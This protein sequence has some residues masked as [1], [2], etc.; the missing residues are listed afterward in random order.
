[1][2]RVWWSLA[3]QYRSDGFLRFD[4]GVGGFATHVHDMQQDLSEA[5]SVLVERCRAERH[6]LR[7]EILR[8]TPSART[9]RVFLVG[10]TREHGIEFD[11]RR[12]IGAYDPSAESMAGYPSRIV[13]CSSVGP[14]EHPYI[15]DG[16]HPLERNTIISHIRQVMWMRGAWA[17]FK[18]LRYT[19]AE[20]KIWTRQLR[21]DSG[22][23]MGR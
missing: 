19:A 20:L 17:R 21:S 4:Q 13:C 15:L 12:V 22:F 14:A 8:E 16:A 3:D 7:V 10:E 1:M 2:E 18:D 23:L 11:W 6:Q 5:S 9:S